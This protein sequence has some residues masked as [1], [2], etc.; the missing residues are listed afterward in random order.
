[1]TDMMKKDNDISRVASGLM[2]VAVV[3]L[4]IMAGSRSCHLGRSWDQQAG[5]VVART[6]RHFLPDGFTVDCPLLSAT[7]YSINRLGNLGSCIR[8]DHGFW[9][10]IL[11]VF[12]LGRSPLAG[13]G[14]LCLD[15]HL[16]ASRTQW[17]YTVNY[18]FAR[19]SGIRLI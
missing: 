2:A 11:S 19:W 8:D 12:R 14:S 18:V 3:A 13:I 10:R 15:C 16:E 7:P 1:M 17:A 4:V 9:R 6:I 5:T